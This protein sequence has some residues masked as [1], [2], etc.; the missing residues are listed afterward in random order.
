VVQADLQQWIASGNVRRAASALVVD[1]GSDV[2][3]TCLAMV[4][5]RAAAEDLT[6]DIFSDAIRG[7]SSYRGEST[8]RTWLLSIARHRC[9]DF[10]RARK[11]DPWGGPL[12]EEND[13]DAQPDLDASGP[14]WLANR[15]QVNLAL[16]ALPEGDRAL[17]VLRFKNGLEYDELAT[18]FGL[19]PGT[20]RMRVSRALARMREALEP[21]PV[22]RARAP[23]PPPAMAAPAPRA[24]AAAAPAP[25]PPSWWQRLVAWARG[26][27]RV[28]PTPVGDVGR[29]LAMSESSAP[30]EALLA[31]LGGLV[32]SLPE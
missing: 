29:S 19:R 16:E 10:L 32:G 7:L 17:V 6:Q 12:S 14:E 9:I 21:A 2:F 25:A 18:A 20:V 11:R 4:R 3:A 23:V 31:R 28:P 22:Q 27:S 1:Y 5:N 8:P 24:V 13:P 26:P 30:S 15:D